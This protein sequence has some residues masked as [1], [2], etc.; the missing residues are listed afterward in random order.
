MPKY[1]IL[2]S[3]EYWQTLRRAKAEREARRAAQPRPD[4]V[5]D[6]GLIFTFVPGWAE[7]VTSTLHPNGSLIP[8]PGFPVA[9]S[10]ARAPAAIMRAR[11]KPRNGRST[12]SFAAVATA[13]ATQEDAVLLARLKESPLAREI[14]KQKEEQR[15]LKL[16]KVP[17]I[18]AAENL[19]F[20]ARKDPGRVRGPFA[21]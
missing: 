10:T 11:P 18:D 21:Y 14:R 3:G 1:E 17:K 6:G 19:R 8:I 16:G 9:S 2:H 12:N 4:Y 20:V 5:P 7:P 13:R 15:K